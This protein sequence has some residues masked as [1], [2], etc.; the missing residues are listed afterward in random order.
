MT[1]GS[2]TQ[3]DASS[4]NFVAP[5]YSIDMAEGEVCFSMAL[6]AAMAWASPKQIFSKHSL[7]A[8]THSTMLKARFRA[9][10]RIRSERIGR[11]IVHGR[12]KDG[13]NVSEDSGRLFQRFDAFQKPI[14]AISLDFVPLLHSVMRALSNR[15]T[16]KKNHLSPIELS[17][18]TK[19]TIVRSHS[20][21]RT[22]TK[23][24]LPLNGDVH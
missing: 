11:G 8:G 1:F 17:Q 2:R 20:M 9:P 15:A 4:N 3:T 24:S 18:W 16:Q 12:Q 7:A 10:K 13:A 19:V 21:P 5:M 6:K 22:R 23:G 14:H